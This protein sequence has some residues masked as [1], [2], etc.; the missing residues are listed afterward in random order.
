MELGTP[1]GLGLARAAVLVQG[2][3]TSIKK[4]QAFVSVWDG[5]SSL[6]KETRVHIVVCTNN[7]LQSSISNLRAV[8]HFVLAQCYMVNF[9]RL[10]K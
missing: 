9:T 5:V 2:S 8:L 7:L 3:G 4:Y 1:V 6:N 10:I